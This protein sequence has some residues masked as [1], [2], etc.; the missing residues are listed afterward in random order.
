VVAN[1][2]ALVRPGATPTPSRQAATPSG[3]VP[4]PKPSAG[5]P[6]I[7]DL[8]L[9]AE[10]RQIKEQRKA[11]RLALRALQDIASGIPEENNPL[12]PYLLSSLPDSKFSQN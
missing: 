2:Q 9:E 11:Q 10:R 1:A 8:L 12:L 4:S 6:E 3:Y 7:R 5:V